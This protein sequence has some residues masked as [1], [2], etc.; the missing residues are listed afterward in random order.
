MNENAQSNAT[1]Q[2]TKDN[3]R[4]DLKIRKWNRAVFEK[5]EFLS[6][7]KGVSRGRSINHD[8]SLYGI[9]S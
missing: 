4:Q 9:Y 5:V 1:K 7:R 8:D 3:W 6:A 2:H